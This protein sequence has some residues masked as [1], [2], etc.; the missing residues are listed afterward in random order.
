MLH[1][2]LTATRS[3]VNARGFPDHMEAGPLRIALQYRYE[4]GHEDD[5]VTAIVPLHMLNQLTAEPFGWLVPG[6]SR[7]R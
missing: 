4:P 2:R 1:R 5:G 6:F 3:P 7:R